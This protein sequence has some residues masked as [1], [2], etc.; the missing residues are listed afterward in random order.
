MQAYAVAVTE[1]NIRTAIRSEAGRSF[2]LDIALSWLEEHQGGWFLR[3]ENSPLDCEMFD[4]EIFGELY[5]F[6]DYDQNLI[7]QKVTRI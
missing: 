1:A 2:D 3:D 6:V 7:F 4:A 5:K